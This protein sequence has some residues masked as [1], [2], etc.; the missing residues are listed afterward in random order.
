M[1]VILQHIVVIHR[2][3]D[4]LGRCERAILGFNSVLWFVSMVVGGL[5]V[6][7]L[8]FFGGFF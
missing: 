3:L 1:E 4:V 2:F 7:V 8:A 5:F 6:G